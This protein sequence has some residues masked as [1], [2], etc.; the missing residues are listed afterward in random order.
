MSESGK[1][2]RT[3]SGT[4]KPVEPTPSPPRA[5]SPSGVVPR[6]P[7]RGLPQDPAQRAKVLAEQARADLAKGQLSSAETNLRLALTFTPADAGLARE[8]R[9]V[10]EAKDQARRAKP[11]SLGR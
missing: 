7:S 11:P 10:V 3:G 9:A 5:S 8:L 6:T 2:I 1:Y 4:W